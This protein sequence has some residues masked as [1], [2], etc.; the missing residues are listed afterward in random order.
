M[1]PD[2]L[3]LRH[4]KS[5]YPFL[6][7]AVI[8]VAVM[9]QVPFL[10]TLIFSFIRWNLS[11]PDMARVFYGLRNY[12]YFLRIRSLSELH[13]FYGVFFQTIV[14]T[15]MTILFCSILGFLLAILFDHPVPGVNIARTLILGPFF[16]M[17][18]A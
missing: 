16:V 14:I 9:T 7:P 17:S 10:M 4:K 12:T 15:L 13:Q 8:I 1:M 6:L 11:R 18:T 5:D 2:G 3:Q